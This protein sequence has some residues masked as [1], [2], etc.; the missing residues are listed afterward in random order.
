MVRQSVVSSNLSSVG[1]DPA[2]ATLE[3]AFHNGGIYQYFNIPSSVHAGLL[4]APS[5]GSYLH[6]FIRGKYRYRKVA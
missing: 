1:Y 3:I 4:T 2:T 6:R 5:K